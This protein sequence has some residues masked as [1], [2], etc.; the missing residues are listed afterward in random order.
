MLKYIIHSR[1]TGTWMI[2]L[3]AEDFS[4]IQSVSDNSYVH[5]IFMHGDAHVHTHTHTTMGVW[6]VCRY[7]LIV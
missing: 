6:M 4:Y 3:P 7:I 1:G 5:V 2:K